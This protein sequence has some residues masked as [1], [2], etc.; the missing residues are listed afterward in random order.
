MNNLEQTT[1][2][3]RWAD[4][5]AK[6]GGS[7]TFIGIF[8]GIMLFW[9]GANVYELTHPFDPYPFILLNLVLSCLAALQAPIIMMSQNRQNEKDRI[10]AEFDYNINRKAEAEIQMLHQKIDRLLELHHLQCE[11]FE[12]MQTK[13]AQL[14]G[15]K[16]P[17]V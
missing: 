6:F 11:D 8:L 9:I 15:K 7:W 14:S 5:I 3:Q 12:E 13:I 10:Q 4:R 1:L 16:D 2:G 17:S